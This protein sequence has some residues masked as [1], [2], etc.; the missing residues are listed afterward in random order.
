MSM[1][2]SGSGARPRVDRRRDPR[3]DPSLGPVQNLL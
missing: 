1:T 3:P 2:I